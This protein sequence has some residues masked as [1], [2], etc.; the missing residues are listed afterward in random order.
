MIVYNAFPVECKF[1]QHGVIKSTWE[2]VNHNIRNFL[3]WVCVLG[4]Y[5][6][7]LLI[8]GD[9]KLYPT[10]EETGLTDVFDNVLSWNQLANNFSIASEYT[11]H[12]RYFFCI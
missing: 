5:C 2:T 9:Y 12:E 3:V 8:G 6:S 10:E 7:I 11:M 4:M 1:D